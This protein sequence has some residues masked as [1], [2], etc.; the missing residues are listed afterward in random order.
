MGNLSNIDTGHLPGSIAGLQKTSRQVPA[1]IPAATVD[2]NGIL[3]PSAVTVTA[4]GSVFYVLTCSAPSVTIQPISGRNSGFANVFGVGQGQ[5][6]ADGFETLQLSNNTTNS[7]VVLLWVGF[8]DFINDQLIL[9]QQQYPTVVFPTY[10]QPVTNPA[11]AINIVD[12]SG[13]QIVDINGKS[14]LALYR[15]EIQMSNLD[16]GAV[17][18]LQAA[19]AANA[20]SPAVCAIQ[21]QDTIVRPIAGNYRILSGGDINMIVAE[22]YAVTKAVNVG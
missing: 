4:Q 10:S 19:N 22:L 6:V 12:R 5:T 20:N 2:A 9:T 13:T 18:T 14:W 17:Y 1:L 11:T 3:T 7:V 15:V 16:T 21:P 8:N